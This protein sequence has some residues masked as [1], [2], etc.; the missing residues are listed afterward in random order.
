MSLVGT[1]LQSL[2]I[3]EDVV[4]YC[5]QTCKAKD[6]NLEGEV[7]EATENQWANQSGQCGPHQ[8]QF[9]TQI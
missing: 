7:K 4:A 6:E 2:V 1:P 3:P 9:P 5:F 8:R